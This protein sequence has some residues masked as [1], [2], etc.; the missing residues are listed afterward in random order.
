MALLLASL[1]GSVYAAAPD[2]EN[3][4]SDNEGALAREYMNKYGWDEEIFLSREWQ[5]TLNGEEVTFKREAGYQKDFLED[6]ILTTRKYLGL[7]EG[8]TGGL[9]SNG[10]ET[11]VKVALEQLAAEDSKE[12][13]PGSNNVKYN[14]WFYG[15]EVSGEEY[16]WSCIFVSWCA[17]QCGFITSGL[18]TKTNS[19]AALYKYLVNENGFLAY[20]TKNTTPMAGSE[21]TPEAGDLLFF[22]E[23]E[24]VSSCTNVGII[25]KVT[26]SGIYVVEG[27][28]N[29][30]VRQN[31]YTKETEHEAAL[32]GYIVHI[33]YPLSFADG[34]SK[35]ANA[36]IIF[37]FLTT[38]TNMTPAAAC[39]VL[40]NMTAESSLLPNTM[41]YGY[42]WETGA[43]Y[44]LIQWT[45]V[46]GNTRIRTSDAVNTI[47]VG[48]AYK[49]IPG[50]RRTNL[51]NWCTAFGY[52]YTSLA[53]QLYFLKYEL[54]SSTTYTK[55]ISKM[56][57]QPNTLE[58]AQQCSDIWLQ[59]IEGLPKTNRY[60]ATQSPE[61]KNNTVSFWSK[62]SQS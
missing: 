54:E 42:T 11:L 52:D 22:F 6:N 14:T 33:Q 12:N 44:G 56:N 3:A 28:S 47:S 36:P 34:G 55:A 57:A 30:Q 37:N 4:F 38:Y 25:V 27:N 48:Q 40:G 62:F 10:A 1:W 31:V 43:G 19:C 16:P 23:G 5:A 8:G 21:Y 61:R 2:I 46:S 41:E 39:G 58:G 32:N 53:G 45:N 7:S 18:F 20:E 35:E 29:D 51:V 17:E 60:W 59:Y 49:E 50:H 13:P 24:D 26:S 15:R 9:E